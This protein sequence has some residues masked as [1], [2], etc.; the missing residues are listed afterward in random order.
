MLILLNQ[1]KNG[2]LE[3]NNIHEDIKKMKEF[4]SNRQ[5]LII[6]ISG[7]VIEK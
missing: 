5:Q 4:D 1:M 2:L 7:N 3:I 6:S